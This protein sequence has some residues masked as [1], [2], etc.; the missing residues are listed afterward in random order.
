M[1]KSSKG[2]SFCHFREAFQLSKNF[3]ALASLGVVPKASELFFE[4]IGG[5][6]QFVGGQQ[7]LERPLSVQREVLVVGKQVVLLALDEPPVIARDP[8][9]FVST[10]FVQGVAQLPQDV[11]FVVEYGRFGVGQG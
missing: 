1:A 7:C 6:E 8:Y 4:H 3:L 5:I 9:V 10:N 2:F 11:E